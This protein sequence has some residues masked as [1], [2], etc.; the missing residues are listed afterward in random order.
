MQGECAGT[1]KKER[2]FESKQR[3]IEDA[4]NGLEEAIS[5]INDA[6]APAIGCE[7]P[8]DSEKGVEKSSQNPSAY[9]SAMDQIINRIKGYAGQLHD[10]ANR[11]EI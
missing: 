2:G 10:I 3:G 7:S 9:A 8:S 6:F 1:I 5:H 4:F 11:S